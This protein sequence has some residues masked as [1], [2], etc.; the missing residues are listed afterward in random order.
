M[1]NR[2]DLL[3]GL[4]EMAAQLAHEI[5]NPLGGIKGFATLLQQDL[6][7]RPRQQEMAGYIHTGDRSFKWFGVS[8]F[9]LYKD[10]SAAIR[11]GR[12]SAFL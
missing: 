2:Q 8:D 6:Q 9:A 4:G 3:K 5:R 12:S 11:N 1:V 7:D 10:F